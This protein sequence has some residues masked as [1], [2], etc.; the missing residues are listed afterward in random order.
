MRRITFLVHK[1]KEY[2]VEKYL[3][4]WGG[5]LASRV[6]VRGYPN[7]RTTGRTPWK[8]LSQAV[9]S[10]RLGTLDGPPESG[11]EGQ[12]YVFTDVDRLDAAETASALELRQR[13]EGDPR[14]LE[15]LN[16]PSRS[17]R[18]FELLSTLHERGINNFAVYRA[19]EGIEPRRWPVFLRDEDDHGHMS[20]LVRTP[21]ELRRVLAEQASLENKI[22]VELCDT[23]DAS[24]VV[25][26]YGAFKVGERIL[27]RQVHFSRHWMV[28]F[29]DLKDP[30]MAREE[31]AYV[32]E[33]P[34]AEQLNEIFRLA[35]TDYGRI[36]YSLSGG[37]IQVWEINTNPMILIP[38]DR[39][40][41]L[42]RQAHDTFGRAFTAVLEE[43]LG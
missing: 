36:D 13:L 29:P 30:A 6:A 25:R 10:W 3:K 14:T 43:W 16:H 2:T 38:A 39:E 1:G 18:R 24:G 27:A 22:V 19:E 8:R 31:L 32:E 21:Q 5:A 4:S 12:I 42:R 41:P 11:S 26:K 35:R 40:D 34:H 33:N 15:I 17:M 7:L 23:A 9:R 37:R 20:P 28:R